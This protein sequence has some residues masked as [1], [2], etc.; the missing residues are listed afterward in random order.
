M[1]FLFFFFTL[2]L[3]L[4]LQEMPENVKLCWLSG[5]LAAFGGQE[6]FVG[7]FLLS[8]RRSGSGP[9]G[10]IGEELSLLAAVRVKTRAGTHR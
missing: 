7:A 10:G 8:Q 4:N 6:T 9:L 2:T 1:F 3:V 5:L